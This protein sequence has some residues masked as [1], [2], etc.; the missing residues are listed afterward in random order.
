M[1]VATKDFKERVWLIF[2]FDK[3]FILLT[4]MIGLSLLPQLLNRDHLGSICL[5]TSS[6]F[7]LS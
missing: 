5:W 3:F 2:F 6:Y 4:E 1:S 7:L